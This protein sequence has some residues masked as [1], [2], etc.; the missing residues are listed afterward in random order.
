M[1]WR[2]DDTS[3]GPR[4]R[5]EG[6]RGQAVAKTT[7][8][9][10]RRRWGG[11]GKTVL[12]GCKRVD[13]TLRGQKE[14][15]EEEGQD[16]EDVSLSAGDFDLLGEALEQDV[17]RGERLVQLVE[18]AAHSDQVLRVQV[19]TH[20]PVVLPRLRLR[21]R[22]ASASASCS[23]ACVSEHRPYMCQSAT[24]IRISAM[25][26]WCVSLSP[27]NLPRPSSQPRRTL[28]PQP[29]PSN[30]QPRLT[31][32]VWSLSGSWLAACFASA[33]HL[34]ARILLRSAGLK[35]DGQCSSMSRMRVSRFAAAR[36]T[37]CASPGSK[38]QCQ[39]VSRVS[40]SVESVWSG[41]ECRKE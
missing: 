39:R 30:P 27:D 8:R 19:L 7:S 24:L 18:G 38:R 14:E 23:C 29:E 2:T 13:K 25:P 9:G 28:N 11:V 41:K 35:I 26:S 20:F 40:K 36:V 32:Q 33:R 37:W 16:L 1:C 3:R 6:V 5:C 12:R 34:S 15:E 21:P 10:W 31:R 17:Q 4:R 22:P